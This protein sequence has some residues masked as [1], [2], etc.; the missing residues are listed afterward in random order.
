MTE[1]VQRAGFDEGIATLFFE[2]NDK[3]D[4]NH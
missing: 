4:R 1:L 3:D 2:E